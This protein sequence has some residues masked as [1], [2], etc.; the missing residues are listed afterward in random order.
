[1]PT[2]VKTRTRFIFTV[3]ASLQLRWYGAITYTVDFTVLGV[4]NLKYKNRKIAVKHYAFRGLVCFEASGSVFSFAFC[5]LTP[6]TVRRFCYFEMTKTYKKQWETWRFGNAIWPLCSITYP[7]H[8][9][10][11]NWPKMSETLVSCWGLIFSCLNKTKAKK[12]F[13]ETIEQYVWEQSHLNL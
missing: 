6:S 7:E 10:N 12:E 13:R 11:E 8:R 2:T 9:N 1:M 5:I 3:N 4:M